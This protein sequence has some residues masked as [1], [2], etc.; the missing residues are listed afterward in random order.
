V[1]PEPWFGTAL[2]CPR[3]ADECPGTAEP[4]EEDGCQQ[5]VCTTCG[6]TL[7][8]GMTAQDDGACGA[9]VP[10]ESQARRAPVLVQIGRRP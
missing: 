3:G 2:P 7:I 4:E 5:V 9:G 1:P 6:F 10:L 8:L